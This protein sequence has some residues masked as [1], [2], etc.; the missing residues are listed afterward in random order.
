MKERVITMKEYILGFLFSILFW[1]FNKL[2]IFNYMDLKISTFIKNNY[3]VQ[4]IHITF[5]CIITYFM[6]FLGNNLNVYFSGFNLE[7]IDT[8]NFYNLIAGFFILNISS[9][10]KKIIELN[11]NITFDNSIKKLSESMVYGFSC[12]ILVLLLTNNTIAIFVSII[13]IIGDKEDYIIIKY[14]R[15]ILCILPALL[16][17]SIIYIIYLLKG[18]DKYYGK[19][20]FNNH[21][22][23]NIIHNPIHNINILA[24]HMESTYFYHHYS[25]DSSYEIFKHGSSN[26]E[27]NKDNIVHYISVLYINCLV[28]FLLF[29]FIGYYMK[30]H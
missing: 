13:L 7:L 21:F 22:V 20:N 24:A 6:Y 11:E 19:P 15:N 10:E 5:A 2:Y 28:I 30:L 8:F 1:R 3:V 14:I 26:K 25:V 12:P 27:P 29:V 18:S 4:A 9:S 17:F 16:S 23:K